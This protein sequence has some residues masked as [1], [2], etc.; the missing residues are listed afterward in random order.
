DLFG[1]DQIAVE[2]FDHGDPLDGRRNDAL[3][4]L[5]RAHRVPVVATNNV[6]YDRP[7]R[8]RM[9]LAVAAVRATRSMDDLDGW[10]PAHGSAHLRSGAE[11]T[12]RFA[13]YPGAIAHG[14]E[15][16]ADC[17][18]PLRR[19]RPALPQQKVPDG[20]TPMSHLRTLVW[21]AVPR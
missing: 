17:A 4:E 10:L 12:E 3:A 16:A 8:A 6:H 9:A 13:R 15:I 20:E 19:A 1:R 7:E 2:L 21:S 11:M 5:A 14:L 18:F